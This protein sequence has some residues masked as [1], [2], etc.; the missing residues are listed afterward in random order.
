MLR[1]IN[2]HGIHVNLRVVYLQY[3]NNSI[4]HIKIW[5]CHSFEICCREFYWRK[6]KEGRDRE[7]ERSAHM[8]RAKFYWCWRKQQTLR[9][10]RETRTHGERKLLASS[11]SV[12]DIGVDDATTPLTSSQVGQI[13]TAR[14][15][16]T[17]VSVFNAEF[18]LGKNFVNF[19]TFLRLIPREF[20]R[21]TAVTVTRARKMSSQHNWNLFAHYE[22]F[23]Q[24]KK[25]TIQYHITWLIPSSML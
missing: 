5:F 10:S 16:S 12:I 4:R 17:R 7:R 22:S 1:L 11:N 19:A 18:F 2:F 15:A 21:L 24:F 20:Q 6:S 9:R 25:E 3:G 14:H 8:R 13:S 23:T